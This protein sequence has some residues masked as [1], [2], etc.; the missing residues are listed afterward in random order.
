[1]NTY[2][3]YYLASLV[4]PIVQ[5]RLPGDYYLGAIIPDVRYAAHVPRQQTHVSQ[6]RLR[7]LRTRHPDLKSFLSGYQVHCLLDEIDLTRVIGPAFPLN[8]I[9]RVTRRKFSQQQLTVLAELY[10]IQNPRLSWKIHETHNEALSDLGIRPDQTTIFLDGM[11]GYLPFP[12]FK[13]AISSFQKL[14]FVESARLEKYMNIYQSLERNPL[15]KAIL[16]WSVR[17]AKVDEFS[18]RYVQRRLKEEKALAERD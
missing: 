2:T 1:M 12:S 10:F 4:E 17:N 16:L 11:K 14:G 5:P 8:L 3:H 13:T 18:V 9:S 6:A 7:E 15:L